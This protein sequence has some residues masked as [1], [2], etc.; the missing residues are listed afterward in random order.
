MHNLNCIDA[1]NRSYIILVKI[2]WNN[3]LTTNFSAENSIIAWIVYNQIPNIYVFPFS[4]SLVLLLYTSSSWGWQLQL[5]AGGQGGGCPSFHQGKLHQEHLPWP[6]PGAAHT[7]ATHRPQ[8]IPVGLVGH[9]LS[10]IS[11]PSTL[12]ASGWGSSAGHTLLGFLGGRTGWIHPWATLGWAPSHL[13]EEWHCLPHS[14]CHFGLGG[15]SQSH[16][17]HT[18]SSS[19]P[20]QWWLPSYGAICLQ[21]MGHGTGSPLGRS[22]HPEKWLECEWGGMTAAAGWGWTCPHLSPQRPQPQAKMTWQTRWV[23]SN[24][25]SFDCPTT[26][27]LN[28]GTLNLMIQPD[29][30]IIT[31]NNRQ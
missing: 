25:V 16:S 29:I 8:S 27:H 19:C 21:D 15:F 31:N 11:S 2:H 5:L 18:S 20:G 1:S 23:R 13:T 12:L 14:F 10:K 17:H 22:S 28:T 4:P 6:L 24:R 30:L 9:R 26:A 7:W 3:F